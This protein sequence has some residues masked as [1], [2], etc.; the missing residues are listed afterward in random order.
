LPIWLLS[1]TDRQL[2]AQNREA[3]LLYPET[4]APVPALLSV[5]QAHG[6]AAQSGGFRNLEFAQGD[7]AAARCLLPSDRKLMLLR[8]TFVLN[9]NAA[10][11]RRDRYLQAF[12]HLL[13]QIVLHRHG[14]AS[15]NETTLVHRVREDFGST[16]AGCGHIEASGLDLA[17]P[18]RTREGVVGLAM[19][20]R[21][22]GGNAR[23]NK[24]AFET[25]LGTIE[26][27]FHGAQMVPDSTCVR[28]SF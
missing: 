1:A 9:H 23:G 19:S 16:V 11:T 2:S 12:A 20:L 21:M 25:R 3:E 24:K 15:A 10:G 14:F 13:A 6:I 28:A 7:H 5:G 4:R 26:R 27:A 17:I 18:S 22:V 8:G